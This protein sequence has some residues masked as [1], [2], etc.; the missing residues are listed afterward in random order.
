MITRTRQEWNVGSKVNV[1]FLK[2]LEVIAWRDVFDGMPDIYLLK[3]NNS[4]YEFIPHNGLRKLV[5]REID[6]WCVVM[7]ERMARV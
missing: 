5:Q 2:G 6:S 7:F 3:R 1:G 4:Y